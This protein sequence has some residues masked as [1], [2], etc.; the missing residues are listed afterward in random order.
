VV[1]R[2]G[3]GHRR[4]LRYPNSN[5]PADQLQPN[6]VPA[7]LVQLAEPPYYYLAEDDVSE[8]SASRRSFFA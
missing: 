5:C 3:R 4:L 2:V 8:E 6:S 1:R 7:R